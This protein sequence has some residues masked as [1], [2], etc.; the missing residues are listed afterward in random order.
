MIL[1]DLSFLHVPRAF[2]LPVPVRPSIGSTVGRD[3]TLRAQDR[4][5]A[6]RTTLRW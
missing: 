1:Q 3:G 5:G 4:G 6:F 2:P